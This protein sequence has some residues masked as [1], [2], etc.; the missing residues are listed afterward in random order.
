M[1]APC[2]D[3]RCACRVIGERE[4]AAAQHRPE[5]RL[6]GL[7]ARMEVVEGLLSSC[8]GVTLQPG[9]TAVKQVSRVHCPVH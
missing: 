3:K 1:P 8:L 9:L 4:G 7:R 2:Q 6:G 5:S